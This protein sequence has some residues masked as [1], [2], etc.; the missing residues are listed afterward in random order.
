[1]KTTTTT[2]TK[3]P[4]TIA[5]LTPLNQFKY[6]TFSPFALFAP[7][8]STKKYP[9]ATAQFVS[10]YTPS[11]AKPS[12][13]T[14]KPITTTKSTTTS[15]KSTFGSKFQILK[16]QST[17]PKSTIPITPKTTKHTFLNSNYFSTTT[18]SKPI[19]SPVQFAKATTASTV[20]TP[21][22]LSSTTK[23]N[24]FDLYLGRLSTKAP[25]RYNIPA[26][27]DLPKRVVT[28]PSPY[29][30]RTSTTPATFSLNTYSTP[31]YFK[32]K[33]T[34]SKPNPQQIQK[35]FE[36]Q[37]TKFA[38]S[39]G[40]KNTTHSTLDGNDSTSRKPRVYRYSFSGTKPAT[41]K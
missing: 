8:Q 11:T 14:F 7:T 41:Q 37:V 32:T 18:T 39:L 16:T 28:L 12:F 35:L 23:L 36:S 40:I 26:I 4:N 24:L 21:A 19:F 29:T 25:E 34:T 30:V 33:S 6:S 17:T 27:P 15:V 13:Q 3:K 22:K 2:T 10:Y 5:T 1:M 38:Q 31:D 20:I 9:T